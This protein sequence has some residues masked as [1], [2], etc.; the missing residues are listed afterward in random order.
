MF[1]NKGRRAMDSFP[2]TTRLTWAVLRY[3]DRAQ[4]WGGALIGIC[5]I[6]AF[7]AFAGYVV[8]GWLG[9]R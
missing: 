9:G 4:E 3:K 7:Y 1:K 2:A 8:L 6:C 5:A